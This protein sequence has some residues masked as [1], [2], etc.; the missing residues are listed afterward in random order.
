M[1]NVTNTASNLANGVGWKA[2]DK[3][4]INN[5]GG[6][7]NATIAQLNLIRLGTHTTGAPGSLAAATVTDLSVNANDLNLID[8]ITTGKVVA[9]A[10]KTITGTATQ[11]VT[12]MTAT[13]I[14]LATNVGVTLSAGTVTA[15]D[16]KTIDA[17]TTGTV[18]ATA[19]TGI[20]GSATDIATVLNSAGITKSANIALTVSTGVAAATDLSSIDAKTTTVINATAVTSITGTAAQVKALYTSIGINISP[21]VNIS[22]SGAVSVADL[23]N[24]HTHTTGVITATVLEHTVNALSTLTGVGNAY[25][26]TVS[27]TTVNAASLNAIDAKTTVQVIATAVKTLTGLAADIATA[28]SSNGISH[29]ANVGVSVSAG[30]VVASDLMTIDKNT[31]AVVNA[32]AVTSITGTAADIANAISSNG[33]NHRAN[34]G[35]TIDAGSVNA[36]DLLTIENKTTANIDATAVTAISGSANNIENAIANVKITLTDGYEIIVTGKATVAD[37]NLLSAYDSGVITAVV[38]NGDIATLLTITPNPNAISPNNLTFNITDSSANAADLLN[39]SYLTTV[40]INATQ[41]STFTGLGSDIASIFSSGLVNFSVNANVII[42][43][44]S[45]N[46]AD[47][48]TIQSYIGTVIDASQVTELTGTLVDIETAIASTSISFT[49][50]PTVL[51]TYAITFADTDFASVTDLNLFS[52]ATS[53]VIT[54]HVSDTDIATLLTFTPADPNV[55]NNLYFT[56]TNDSVSAADLLTLMSE[57]TVNIDATAVSTFTGSAADIAS[58]LGSGLVDYIIFLNVSIDAGSAS[59]A[60]L[61]TIQ[62]YLGIGIVDASQV[63]ELTGTLVD[64]ETAIASTSISFT[65]DPTV[66]PTYA[67]TLVDTDFASV[68]DLN[69]FSA[70]T[71]GVITAHVSNYD[72]ASLLSF[73]PAN[74]ATPNN[75]YFTVTDDSVSAANLLTLM[76][77]T[78]VNI[79]ATAVST[80]TGS[81]ADIAHVVSSGTV[82]YIVFLSATV[83]A[84]IANATDLSVIDS[85]LF[86]GNVDATAVT[87]IN[88]SLADILTDVSSGGITFSSTY[89]VNVTD[90][91]N[92]GTLDSSI[93]TT[94]ELILGA[95]SDASITLDLGA[96][97]FSTIVLDGAGIDTITASAT[98][99]ETF[100]LGAGQQGGTAING[101]IVGDAINID[102]ASAITDLT[103]VNLGTAG[104]VVSAGEWA[105][106]T[107]NQTLTYFNSVAGHAETITLTGVNNVTLASGDI[108]QIA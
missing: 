77:E 78:T 89:N 15:T 7:N 69:L 62:S 38:K 21:S 107:S 13:G 22:L 39:L 57:T 11:V 49:A 29:I 20:T 81:A 93:A 65:A 32:T 64:I 52:A 1:A 106:D 53:G 68:T 17:K 92:L 83:D 4:T 2:G 74:P 31:S 60:D 45:A 70:A 101:L 80:F 16:L 33:I 98:V 3:L 73:V 34:I 6:N 88:G 30:S 56:V 100:V 9:S 102:G 41:I 61:N 5:G 59:A 108:F 66:L 86:L 96:S 95:S 91:G 36:R 10:A 35:V 19:I 63:T 23:N 87:E 47:L 42:D 46:A 18:V 103:G 48:I 14:T 25:A 51:P 54:A 50:D 40:I 84:G 99:L 12:A 94:G 104:S 28:L 58:V 82:D 43:A 24:I 75:L 71:S 79:D 90:T 8:A 37:I 55:A 72:M 26:I 105:F 76:S 44:S 85:N 67:I 27:D 97:N